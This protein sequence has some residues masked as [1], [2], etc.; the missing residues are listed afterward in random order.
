MREST[1]QQMRGFYVLIIASFL[2]I[3]IA[4]YRTTVPIAR[5]ILM[6][7]IAVMCLLEVH[8]IDLNGRFNS[9]SDIYNQ[10]VYRLINPIENFTVWYVLSYKQIR[11]QMDRASDGWTK[12]NRKLHKAL[13][14]S[15]E[16]I[17]LYV[18]PFIGLFWW[19][20]KRPLLYI[21]K[22]KKR[23]KFLLSHLNS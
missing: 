19:R 7:I 12:W 3:I 1:Q 20:F 16:Q 9:V 11:K 8:Q 15:T 23:L 18:F 13:Q 10:D 17:A 6:I 5:D 4:K 21:Y 2:S 22:C 14:P